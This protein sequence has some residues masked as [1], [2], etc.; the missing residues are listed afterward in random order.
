MKDSDLSNKMLPEETNLFFD[1]CQIID[2]IRDRVATYLN[3]EICL[4]NW[5]VGKRI[6]EDV[7]YNQRAEYGKQIVK[8]LAKQL[9]V[10]YG[11]G[12]S[13]RKLL[14]CIRAAYTFSEDEIVYATRIQLTWTHLRSIMYID[15]ELARSFYMEMCHIEHWN[16]RTLNEKIDSQL[17]ECTAISR[18]PKNVVKRELAKVRKTLFGNFKYKL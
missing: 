10:K 16:T 14:H 6:K 4:S 17:Y 12:W 2:N 13:D 3:T 1:V 7:L 9:M 18:K 11:N 5:Y 8:R 15:D